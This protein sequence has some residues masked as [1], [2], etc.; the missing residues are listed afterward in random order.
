V[1]VIRKDIAT[2]VLGCAFMAVCSATAVGTAD[3]EWATYHGDRGLCGTSD[4]ELPRNP[5]QIWSFKA[6][7]AVRATPVVGD[8]RVYFAAEKGRVCALDLKGNKLWSAAPRVTEKTAEGQTTDKPEE[9]LAPAVYIASTVVLGSLNGFVYAFEAA[10]GELRWKH[11][12]GERIQGTVNW[13]GDGGPG[14]LRVIVVLQ[15]SGTVQ[16]LHIGSGVKKWEREGAARC[17]GSPSVGAGRIVFGSCDAGLHVLNAQDGAELDFI[18]LGAGKEIAG[19]VA[20]RGETAFTGNRS[21]SLIRIDVPGQKEV[22]SNAEAEGTELFTTPAIREQRV[23]FAANNGYVYCVEAGTGKTI[24]KHETGGSDAGSPVIA[25]NKVVASAGGKLFVLTLD[26][27]T[28]IWS[29]E[30]S[31]EISGPAVAHGMIVVGTGDGRVVAFGE[32]Q[33]E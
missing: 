4:S 17:D 25:Q 33:A 18:K 2:V 9:F 22:W 15:P 24:W 31:D 29:H 13:T 5:R 7:S 3:S 23:V 14:G 30:V 26:S 19:G 6:G 20:L 10:T 16:A 21:G 8:N 32:G 28:L 12:A 27:G 1:R 11:E